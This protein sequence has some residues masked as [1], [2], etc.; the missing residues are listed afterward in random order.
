[1]FADAKA[2]HKKDM[3]TAHLNL[4]IGIAPAQIQLAGDIGNAHKTHQVTLAGI[5]KDQT[6]AEFQAK[7]DAISAMPLSSFTTD[8]LT[9]HSS[10]G[11]TASTGSWTAWFGA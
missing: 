7:I 4:A 10:G 11:G 1:V 8:P 6:T 2:Q 9:E 5:A 3:A